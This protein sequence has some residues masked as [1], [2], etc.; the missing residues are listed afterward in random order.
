MM[1]GIY[2]RFY[3]RF[4]RWRNKTIH[5]GYDEQVL[6]VALLFMAEVLVLC[7]TVL[8]VIILLFGEL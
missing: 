6:F 7:A 3:R 1:H 2:Y 8:T 5:S 4:R